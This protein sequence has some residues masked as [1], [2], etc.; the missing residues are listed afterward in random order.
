MEVQIEPADSKGVDKYSAEAT[1]GGGK[2]APS[3]CEHKRIIS[4]GECKIVFSK[5][6]DYT[7]AASFK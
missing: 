6:S 5:L 7:R 2:Y 4:A 1:V 3:G